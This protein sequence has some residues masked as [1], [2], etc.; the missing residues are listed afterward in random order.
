MCVVF[1][2]INFNKK[3]G[4]QKNKKKLISNYYIMRKL[5]LFDIDGTI[6]ESGQDIDTTMENILKKLI[7]KGFIIGIVGGGKLDKALQ[8]LGNTYIHHYFTECGCV[9]HENQSVNPNELHLVP[10]YVKNI[11]EHVLY[12]K[13]NILI[14]Q[15]L[16]FLSQVKYT[17]TGNFIDLRNGIIYISL[18]GLSA[19]ND[20]RKYFMELDAMFEYR[21]HLLDIL[22]N[23][24]EELNIS[25]EI[26]IYEGG[27]VGIAI[28]PVEY[29]KTQVL[30][31]LQD[32]YQDIYYF[33]D[34]YLKNGNDHNLINHK[35][36]FGYSVDSVSDTQKKLEA[37]FLK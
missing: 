5:L 33:G 18:I 22:Q 11:R 14:K 35:R 15:A 7:E 8:Q 9:Y 30:E 2:K 25:S 23:L 16:Y 36:V 26:C 37:L 34:K 1:R 27:S 13:I 20:E 10:V 17:L 3:I 28:Y 21:K 29:D 6:A 24:A 31:S 19:N 12:P 4:K 32:K